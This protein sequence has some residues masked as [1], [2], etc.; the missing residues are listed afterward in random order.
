MTL[1]CQLD[2]T[3]LGPQVVKETLATVPQLAANVIEEQE[4]TVLPPQA[5]STLRYNPG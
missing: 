5:L 3:P 2:I 1:T 4:A